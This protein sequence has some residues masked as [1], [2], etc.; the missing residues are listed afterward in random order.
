MKSRTLILTLVC[1]KII[2]AQAYEIET[3]GLFTED[4]FDHSIIGRLNPA[5]AEI[6]QRLGFDRLDPFRGFDQAGLA[7]CANPAGSAP[8][9]DAYVDP[10]ASWTG[11]PLPDSSNVKFRCSQP[12]VLADPS[13]KLV[14]A[15]IAAQ[16]VIAQFQQLS[17]FALIKA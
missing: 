15:Q 7:D 16:L 6:Y 8:K 11:T 10:K 1:M 2:N 5:S 3:H 14:L 4:A 9:L 12:Y 13:T 17:R